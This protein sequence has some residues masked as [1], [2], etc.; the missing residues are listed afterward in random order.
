M[1][2]LEQY[3]RTV[4]LQEDRITDYERE[5]YPY[6]IPALKNFHCMDLHPRVTYLMGE[7]GSGKSTLVEAIAI[8]A[9][10]NAEGGS[11][12]FNFHSNESHSSLHHAIRLV[13][14]VRRPKDGFFFRAESFYNV[15]TE[16]DSLGVQ[17]AYGGRSLHE[18]SHGESFMSLL[19]NR[20]APN[21]L[22]ILD[23][24][25][26]ALS[27]T[28]QMAALA[29]IHRLAQSNSQF[30]IATHSPILMS[31]PDSKILHFSENGIESIKLENTDHYIVTRRFVNNPQAILNELLDYD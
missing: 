2:I 27:P 23:E 4:L 29:H 6:N 9:G 28:R 21:G 14:G 12:N 22:Y 31:Y 26:A 10:Y 20:F 5:Q 3:L 25:E 30:I 19:L 7:N 17:G 18:Q 13:R 16:I 11:R 8:A 1:H 24:P 15:A